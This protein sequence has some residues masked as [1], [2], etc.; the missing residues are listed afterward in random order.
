M[1]IAVRAVRRNPTDLLRAFP[2]VYP[3]PSRS[4][5]TGPSSRNPTLLLSA[6]PTSPVPVWAKPLPPSQSHR[7]AQDVSDANKLLYG[8]G[9]GLTSQSHLPA[10]AFPTFGCVFTRVVLTQPSQSHLPA[11]AFSTG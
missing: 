11:R 9:A 2:T 1:K 5:S 10:Q 3:R 8:L 6:F 7:T 4:S